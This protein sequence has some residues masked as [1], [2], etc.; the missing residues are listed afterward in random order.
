MSQSCSSLTSNVRPK[1]VKLRPA[2]SEHN[3]AT[4]AVQLTVA[5]SS[6]GHPVLLSLAK[7]FFPS[8]VLS[9]LGS[10]HEFKLSDKSL[11]FNDPPFIRLILDSLVQPPDSGR[12]VQ[13]L[14]PKN[15]EFT[16]GNQPQTRFFQQFVNSIQRKVS[17]QSSISRF[18]QMFT[19]SQATLISIPAGQSVSSVVPIELAEG[20]PILRRK[21]MARLAKRKDPLNTMGWLNVSPRAL[22]IEAQESMSVSRIGTPESEREPLMFSG[23]GILTSRAIPPSPRPSSSSGAN[24]QR[25]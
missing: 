3:L 20:Q 24:T 12:S 6:S 11:G 15:P 17:S 21:R 8:F 7:A 19:T 2:T 25:T 18:A 14:L 1:A 10:L 9:H 16:L 4:L 5:S 13:P 22:A 23:S